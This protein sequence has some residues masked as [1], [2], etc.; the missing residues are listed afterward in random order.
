MALKNKNNLGR[1][2]RGTGQNRV[3]SAPDTTYTIMEAAVKGAIEMVI[4]DLKKDNDLQALSTAVT[5]SSSTLNM[6]AALLDQIASQMTE[7]VTTIRAAKILTLDPAVLLA[8]PIVDS[9]NNQVALNSLVVTGSIDINGIDKETLEKLSYFTQQIS[10]NN[11]STTLSDLLASVKLLYELTSTIQ[12]TDLVNI[13]TVIGA[14]GEIYSNLATITNKDDVDITGISEMINRVGSLVKDVGNLSGGIPNVNA[15]AVKNIYN[16]ANTLIDIENALFSLSH[17]DE[18]RVKQLSSNLEIMSTV[19]TGKKGSR[20]INYTLRSIIYG[21]NN[22]EI[23]AGTAKAKI[24]MIANTIESVTKLFTMANNID[25]DETKKMLA[26]LCE[27]L[28]P[29]N[30]NGFH[31]VLQNIIGLKDISP[32]IAG[33]A[34]QVTGVIKAIASVNREIKLADVIA[35]DMK[36]LQLNLIAGLMD[37]LVTRIAKINKVEDAS[38]RLAQLADIFTEIKNIDIKKINSIVAISSTATSALKSFA[39]AA[40]FGLPAIVGVKLMTVF[41]GNT[42]RLIAIINHI[43]VDKDIDK[44]VDAIN[45]LIIGSSV[46]LILGAAASAF[47]MENI[48]SLMSFA[49]VLGAFVSSVLFTLGKVG[50]VLKTKMDSVDELVKLISGCALIL[51]LG[52]SVFAY[53]PEVG[54]S[55]LAFATVLGAFLIAVGA[56]LKL[57]TDVLMEHTTDIRDLTVLIVASAGILVLG[58][59][60]GAKAPELFGPAI[61]FT[62]MLG[63]FIVAMMGAWA[64]GDKLSG[65]GIQESMDNALKFGLL[66]AISGAVLIAGAMIMKANGEGI[67][68]AALEF[69]LLLGTFVTGIC[70]LY[71]FTG[72]WLKESIKA[73][74]EFAGLVAI[75]GGILLAGAAIMMIPGIFEGAMKF[76]GAFA[77]FSLGILFIF[78]GM[79]SE[80]KEAGKS[81]LLFGFAVGVITVTLLIAG[82]TIKDDWSIVGAIVTFVAIT[83]VLLGGMVLIFKSLGSMNTGALF[84]AM[85]SLA[86]IVGVIAAMGYVMGMVADVNQKVGQSGGWS[87]MFI[88]LGWMATAIVGAGLL[89]A[90]II[91]IT[92]ATGG[93]GAL[94]IGIAEGLLAGLV[95]I[96]WMAAEAIGAMVDGVMKVKQAQEYIGEDGFDGIKRFITNFISIKDSFAPLAGIG[97]SLTLAVAS[98]SIGA[99]AETLSLSAA[100]IVDI[101][102]MEIPEYDANGRPTGKKIHIDTSVITQAGEAAGELITAIGGAIVNVYEKNPDMFPMTFGGLIDSPFARVTKSVSGI[103]SMMSDIASGIKT[104]AGMSIPIY[105]E[106]GNVIGKK[107][108]GKEE[109]GQAQS[110]IVSII[111]ALGSAIIGLYSGKMYAYDPNS[112]KIVE[113]QMDD[114]TAQ[115]AKEMFASEGFFKRESKFAK[116]VQACSYLG[117]MISGIANGVYDMASLLVNEVDEQG[118]A[119][120]RKKRLTEIDFTNAAANVEKIITALGTAIIN[121]YNSENGQK[122]FTDPSFFGNSAERTPFSMVVRSMT[123]IDELIN[124]AVKS[125][126]MVNGNATIAKLNTDLISTRITRV[127]TCLAKGVLAAY[128]DKSI[129]KAF[130]V[131]ALVDETDPEKTPVGRVKAALASIASIADDIR[132]TTEAVNNA[133][134]DGDLFG[135]LN[136]GILSFSDTISK[137]KGNPEFTKEV[138]DMSKFISNVNSLDISKVSKMVTLVDSINSLS[139]KF[140][141]LDKFTQSIS[142]QMSETFTTLANEIQKSTEII[143]KAEKMSNERRENIK[144]LVKE[145]KDVMGTGLDVTI[146]DSNDFTDNSRATVPGLSGGQSSVTRS[147]GGLSGLLGGKSTA[148]GGV[149]I[150][151]TRLQ[152]II[153]SAIKAAGTNQ[154]PIGS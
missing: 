18:E 132:V 32:D 74:L 33:A 139:S 62:L 37:S 43:E 151:Y 95:G 4:E 29:S 70:W 82:N 138:E 86:F 114:V 66:V 40:V 36:M 14:I 61:V 15:D 54:V 9:S 126:E 65:G 91:A 63:S 133:T 19:I 39:L 92:T 31:G 27:V 134:T 42:A 84:K 93:V 79:K 13:Y 45:K 122:I 28:S 2:S 12:G 21:L 46:V 117:G 22:I 110:N 73:S 78:S 148:A 131:N 60:I 128:N 152:S 104:F 107:N 67:L 147:Q 146:Y 112:Q 118:N 26:E 24:E 55:A 17:L 119:T 80:V 83:G 136:S 51:V 38:E 129:S 81:A 34:N 6:S 76:A 121:T 50:D 53:F 44:K 141:S 130:G 48:L 135:N 47:A 124:S 64:L 103:G 52:G 5:T 56:A 99:M 57:G 105:D 149:S 59:M 111:T 109:I 10:V 120:G 25:A 58:A 7:L 16:V 137:I 23:D 125:I 150:D 41:F 77:L 72:K 69:T 143:D 154:R 87:N 49:T 140:D 97:T 142:K 100:A 75:S 11:L 102:S 68:A 144:N 20:A 101:A 8:T 88:A 85:L 127:I 30:E 71:A 98:K 35:L 106:N 115:A 96:V 89:V 3:P 153:I 108:I 116:A 113:K 94:A 123:G 145:V 1:I 90:A